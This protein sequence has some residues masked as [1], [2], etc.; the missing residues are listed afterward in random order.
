V[1]NSLKWINWVA[2]P[3]ACAAKVSDELSEHI[4]VPYRNI[5]NCWNQ[6][7]KCYCILLANILMKFTQYILCMVV[8]LQLGTLSVNAESFSGQVLVL[9]GDTIL[10][11]EQRIRLHG[12]DAPESR[13]SCWDKLDKIYRCGQISTDQMVSYTNGKIV[14][15]EVTDTDRYGRLVARCSID[16]ENLS[17]RLVREGWALAY[18]RYSRDYILSEEQAERAN[19]G[20]W[21][22]RFI[23]PW[24]WRKGERLSS[25]Q[26]Q[27][28]SGCVIK[29]NISNS[30]KIYHTPKSPWYSRTKINTQKGERWFCSEDEAEAAGWR[31]P[32]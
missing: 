31:A 12:I 11:R 4:L 29:G 1:L 15:C 25:T 6:F 13:Q 22:G 5:T 9:D 20:I 19:L 10:M 2:P 7:C 24:K 17:E 3:P 28:L 14:H 30:G 27:E 23:E 32:D 18:R 8:S 26:Q 16:G 21:Q